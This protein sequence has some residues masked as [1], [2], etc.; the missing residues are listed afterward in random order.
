[1][2]T[3]KTNKD[4][5]IALAQQAKHHCNLLITQCDSWLPEEEGLKNLRKKIKSNKNFLL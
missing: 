1:M 4:N 3:E 5:I 2:I